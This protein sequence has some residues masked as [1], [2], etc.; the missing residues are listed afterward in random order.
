MVPAFIAKN[1]KLPRFPP[2][3]KSARLKNPF[4]ILI[5]ISNDHQPQTGQIATI[6]EITLTKPTTAPIEINLGLYSSTLVR[7]DILGMIKEVKSI[8][9][10]ISV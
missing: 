9:D 4:H 5:K 7:P 6:N 10:M 1:K 3:R 8:S 2:G